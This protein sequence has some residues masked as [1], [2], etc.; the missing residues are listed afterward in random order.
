MTFDAC[1]EISRISK[2]LPMRVRLSVGEFGLTVC[3]VIEQTWGCSVIS[4][5]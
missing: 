2:R 5:R 4:E 3:G 1:G